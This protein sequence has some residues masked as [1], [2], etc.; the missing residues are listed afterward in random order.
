[1]P[2]PPVKSLTLTDCPGH[3]VDDDVCEYGSYPNQ[4][5]MVWE[6]IGV[7]LSQNRP[8]PIHKAS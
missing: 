6:A 1:M 3:D 4:A 2:K 8:G 5:V 7:T